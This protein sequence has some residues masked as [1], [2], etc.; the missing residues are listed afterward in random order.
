MN[1]YVV[2][3]KKEPY[4][5]YIGRPGKWGNPIILYDERDREKII[6]LYIEWIDL[7]EQKQLKKDIKKELKGKILGCYCSPKLCHG[8]ILAEIANNDN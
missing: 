1:Q 7:P 3:C 8:H 2:H 5:V 4:D 6:E